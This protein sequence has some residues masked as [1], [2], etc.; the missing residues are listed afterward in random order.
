MKDKIFENMFGNTIQV[1]K[2][3][4]KEIEEKENVGNALDYVR[5][6]VTELNHIYRL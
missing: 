6:I 4:F 5:S 2:K 1:I 3:N